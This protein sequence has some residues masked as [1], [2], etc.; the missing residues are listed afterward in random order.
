MFT[1]PYR[2]KQRFIYTRHATA[3]A[4]I[5]TIAS[6][7]TI[8]TD[9]RRNRDGAAGF[10]HQRGGAAPR[11]R[12]TGGLAM[13]SQSCA[14]ARGRQ[15]R[16]RVCF[17][18]D[19]VSLRRVAKPGRGRAHTRARRPC[20]LPPPPARSVKITHNRTAVRIGVGRRSGGA[21]GAARCSDAP[22]GFERMMRAQQNTKLCANLRAAVTIKHLSN[23]QTTM[24]KLQLRF[25][26]IRYLQRQTIPSRTHQPTRA[27]H[28]SAQICLL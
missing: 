14:T 27:R 23:R 15:R 16:R 19:A 11:P 13:R 7:T 5:W 9:G 26:R 2:R 25:R 3:H 4:N 21:V 8:T 1:F 28:V 10:R 20:L 17:S 22:R 18:L 24:L 6:L 12:Q